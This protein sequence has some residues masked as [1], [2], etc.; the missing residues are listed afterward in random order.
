MEA[1]PSHTPDNRDAPHAPALET[2][3]E[4]SERIRKRA[5]EKLPRWYSP[6]GHLLTTTGTGVVMLVLG[7][8]YV[9]HVRPLEWLV[10][11][12]VFVLANLF[13]W[14]AHKHILHRRRRFLEIIYDRH[15]P[16]HHMV[17]TEHAMTIREPRELRLVL[18]PAAGVVGIVIGLAPLAALVGFLVTPNV[19]WLMLLTAALYM[20]TYELSHTSYHLPEDSFIGRRWLVRVLRKHHARH[21]DPELMQRWNF[22]VT[23]PLWDWILGTIAP[24]AAPS[25]PAAGDTEKDRL[26]SR[27]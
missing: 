14:R 21:H 19:G 20:V 11:P 25:S 9:H 26:T 17:F 8:I 24:E 18:I 5:L 6:W 23:L 4:R 1:A 10:P 27:A 22:N 7:V 15:T 2:Q 13:E 12:L 16:V 3:A